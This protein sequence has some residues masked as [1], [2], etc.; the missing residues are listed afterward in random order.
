VDSK[1]TVLKCRN[2]RIVLV[3]ILCIYGMIYVHVPALDTTH[4]VFNA[5][6]YFH[7]EF[8]RAF[9]IEGYGRTSACLL[10]VVS[11][12]LVAA[13]LSGKSA[14]IKRFY[15][16]KFNSIYVPMLIWGLVSILLFSLVSLLQPTFITEVCGFD[17]SLIVSCFDVV[18]HLTAMSDG[19]TMHLAFLRDL[20][21]CMLLAPLLIFLLRSIP[22]ILLAVLLTVYLVDLE[23]VFILR[24]L[25]VLGFSV[26]IFIYLNRCRTFWVDRLWVVW[27][28]L[29]IAITLLIIA[30]NQDQLRELQWA[31]AANGLDARESF[32]YPL[33]RLFGA[34]SLWSVSSKLLSLQLFRWCCRF[35]PCLFVA[36]CAHPLILVVIHS[37][38][39]FVVKNELA[40]Q[41]YPI[42]FLLAPA[43]AIT[44]AKIGTLAFLW[45]MPKLV[46][47]FK[48][49][50][51]AV[52]AQLSPT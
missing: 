41:L 43:V 52:E 4:G 25:V 50:R 26:G 27:L 15:Q 33:S 19:P 21:V 24:P 39:S 10:S 5:D 44:C 48:G 6:G 45:L 32:F 23:S 28:A 51:C 1:E 9:L 17:R 37:V 29:W 40:S 47:K 16:R 34:L 14:S 49:A 11:G 13:T 7:F 46:Y 42:W 18:F 30:F 3:R 12:Y 2:Q 20:F 38:F 35:E 22:I 31:F 36:F 8:I